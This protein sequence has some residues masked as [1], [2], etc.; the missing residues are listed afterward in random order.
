[1]SRLRK[2]LG[3]T[4]ADRRLLGQAFRVLWL[5][6]LILSIV[7]F[8]TA[9][10]LLGRLRGTGVPQPGGKPSAGRIV[11]AV[12]AA[13]RYVP[14]TRTCF[15]RALAVHT[16][17][18]RHGLTSELRVGVAREGDGAL[19]A[20]AWVECDGRVVIGGGELDRYVAFPDVPLHAR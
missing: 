10:K 11:W 15:P 3:L 18:T 5:I 7:P 9:R 14:R 6:R 19:E 13:S 16:L 12:L 8:G 2:F 1:M 20:H 17:L 4:S